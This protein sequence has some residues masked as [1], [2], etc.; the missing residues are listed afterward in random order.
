MTAVSEETLR[1]LLGRRPGL[2]IKYA[3][4]DDVLLTYCVNL[5]LLLYIINAVDMT[6]AS[7][8]TLIHLLRYLPELK[9]KYAG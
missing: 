9:I 3:G 4:Y 8:E 1:H 5:C 2:K 7:E 6:A